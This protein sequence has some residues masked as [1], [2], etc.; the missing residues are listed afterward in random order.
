MIKILFTIAAIVF[1]SSLMADGVTTCQEK[2]NAEHPSGSDA[3]RTCLENC[4]N[5]PPT[6]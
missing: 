2:C 6:E 4:K 1:G 3:Q 5:V